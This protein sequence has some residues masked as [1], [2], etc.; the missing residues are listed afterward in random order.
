MSDETELRSS[1]S[2]YA[3]SA[4]QMMEKKGIPPKPNNFAVWYRYFSGAYPELARTLDV[5]LEAGLPFT[6]ERNAEIYDRF[7]GVTLDEDFLNDATLRVE[8]ELKKLMTYLE[9]AGTDA[10][11]YGDTLSVVSGELARDDGRKDIR[12]VLE[13]VIAATRTM[14][15]RNLA[16]ET[17]LKESAGEIRSLKEDVESLRHEAMTDALT[18]VAN[19]KLFDEEI[20][21]GAAEAMDRGQPLTLL[22]IDID[23]FKNFNDTHG[24]QVGDQVLR[25]V[26]RILKSCVRGEDLTARY[27]GEEFS[28]VLPNT[29]LKNGAKVGEHVCTQVSKKAV[30]NRATGKSLGTITVSVGAAEFQPGESVESLIERADEALYL[31]KHNGRNRVEMGLTTSPG[32]RGTRQAHP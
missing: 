5:I 2:A 25:F 30:I 13:H 17:R 15:E 18:G 9:E 28:I 11:A 19:R 14:E 12:A 29:T 1:P 16:L 31:A 7:L 27:G 26:A 23:H 6:E 21:I 8:T 3:K 22:M 24:H 20:R 4:L 10:Q 32:G